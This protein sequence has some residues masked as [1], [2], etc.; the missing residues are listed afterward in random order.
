MTDK[1]NL[2]YNYN[3]EFDSNGVLALSVWKYLSFG[4]FLFQLSMCRIFVSIL[5]MDLL[6]ASVIVIFAEVF[7]ISFYIN[8]HIPD[9]KEVIELGEEEIEVK[10]EEIITKMDII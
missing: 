9:P 2:L 8:F 10:R 5:K 3:K 1:Y 4:V 6:I 7:I